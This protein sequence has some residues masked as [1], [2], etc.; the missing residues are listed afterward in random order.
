MTCTLEMFCKWTMEYVSCPCQGL[1]LIIE[2]CFIFYLQ[3]YLTP[4]K[5][6]ELLLKH[7]EVKVWYEVTHLYMKTLF[8]NN[9]VILH[10]FVIPGGYGGVPP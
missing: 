4:T 10:Y 8:M 3:F 6:F 2:W 9:F 1:S 7:F 5:T